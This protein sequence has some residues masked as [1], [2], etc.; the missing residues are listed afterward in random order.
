MV[1][2]A[3]INAI[4]ITLA[5]STGLQYKGNQDFNN[6]RAINDLAHFT[7]LLAAGTGDRL[8]ATI[9]DLGNTGGSPQTTTQT[10]DISVA[11]VDDAPT[12]NTTVPPGLP[13]TLTLVE[14]AT[15]T[16]VAGT[17][18]F[19]GANLFNDVDFADVPGGVIPPVN[20]SEFLALEHF[21]Q[22]RSDADCGDD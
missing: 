12:V 18:P 13:G 4:N 3:P 6:L 7:P 16:F 8:V 22:H 2:T 1:I 21:G 10:V 17:S 11:P 14:N 20:S 5:N 9:N 19:Y 15:Q